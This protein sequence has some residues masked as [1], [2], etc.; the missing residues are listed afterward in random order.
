MASRMCTNPTV[1]AK[2][3]AGKP[4]VHPT[5]KTKEKAHKVSS[6]ILDS[7]TVGGTGS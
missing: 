6:T 5:L 1:V 7:G 3:A 4:L 2:A